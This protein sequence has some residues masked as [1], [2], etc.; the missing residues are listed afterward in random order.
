M[1]KRVEAT[2]KKTAPRR[3]LIAVG[4]RVEGRW[5]VPHEP[6]ALPLRDRDLAIARPTLERGAIPS[7]P[8]RS[9]VRVAETAARVT[10]G[11]RAERL[12]GSER[13]DP[14]SSWPAH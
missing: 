13:G 12:S 5:Q 7:R 4:K 9:I 11:R 14:P 6:L 10:G 2:T 3:R 8:R 1:E